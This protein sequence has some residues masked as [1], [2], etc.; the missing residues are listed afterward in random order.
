MVGGQSHV[1]VFTRLY[2]N[3]QK[4][5]CLHRGILYTEL[6]IGDAQQFSVLYPLITTSKG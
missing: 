2:A 1:L 6:T 3:R 4:C 5:Y